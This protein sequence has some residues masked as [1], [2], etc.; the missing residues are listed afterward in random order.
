V[1]R[2]CTTSSLGREREREI[3]REG[4]EGEREKEGGREGKM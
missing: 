4:G 3:K 2:V 1:Y